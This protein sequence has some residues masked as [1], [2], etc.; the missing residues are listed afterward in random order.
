M[1][2]LL[3]MSLLAIF[4]TTLLIRCCSWGIATVSSEDL[5]FFPAGLPEDY[6]ANLHRTVPMAKWLDFSSCFFMWG[7][8]SGMKKSTRIRF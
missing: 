8:M 4:C 7:V 5:A 6:G 2:A 3:G 1:G